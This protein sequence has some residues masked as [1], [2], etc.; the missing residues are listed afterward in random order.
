MKNLKQVLLSTLLFFSSGVLAQTTTI[1]VVRH[2]EKEIVTGND[3][4]L[5]TVGKVRANALANELKTQPLAAIFTTAY[6]RT[7]QTGEPALKQAKLTSLQ[8][9][10]PAELPAFTKQVLKDYAGRNILVVGHS[11]T[12]ISTVQAFGATKPFDT[13]SDEDYDQL[14]KITVGPDG[15]VNLEVKQYG[16]SHHATTSSGNSMKEN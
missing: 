6:K 13:L 1:W 5:S 9:Y 3:P 14:F 7:A 15:K 2:A 4:D 10:S 11:N 12:V 8:T 16:E